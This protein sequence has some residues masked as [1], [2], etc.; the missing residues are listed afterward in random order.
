M[1]GSTHGQGCTYGFDSDKNPSNTHMAAYLCRCCTA[2]VM[3]ATPAPSILSRQGRGSRTCPPS[4]PV[5]T[6]M[7]TRLCTLDFASR[8]QWIPLGLAAPF[9]CVAPSLRV[10]SS[11]RARTPCH[12]QPEPLSLNGLAVSCARSPRQRAIAPFSA[13]PIHQLKSLQFGSSRKHVA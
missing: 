10:L 13:F 8:R 7:V 11:W 4:P 1:L 9:I 3:Y 5:I 2:A 12:P 6:S